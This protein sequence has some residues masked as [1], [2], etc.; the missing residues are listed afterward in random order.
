MVHKI[1][2]SENTCWDHRHSAPCDIRMKASAP[3]HSYAGVLR[4]S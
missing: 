2:T 1:R 4:T 3:N